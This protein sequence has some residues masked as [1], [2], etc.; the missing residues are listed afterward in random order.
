MTAVVLLP[1]NILDKF[2]PFWFHN[3]F[4]GLRFHI[5]HIKQDIN[6]CSI[7]TNVLKQNYNIS[8]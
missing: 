1:N 3:Y 5:L 8:K 6:I 2:Q 4:V 7:R